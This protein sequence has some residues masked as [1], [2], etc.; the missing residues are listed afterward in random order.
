VGLLVLILVAGCSS[1][2]YWEGEPRARP[3]AVVGD[4]YVRQ[5]EIFSSAYPDSTRALTNSLTEQGWRAHV[6]GENGWPIAR[7]R[8][9]AEAAMAEGAVGLVIV[10]GV[11]DVAWAQHQRDEVGA[12]SAIDADVAALLDTAS[13]AR[14]VVWPTV[15]PGPR[16]AHRANRAVR[17]INDALRR[18]ASD[19]VVVPEWGRQLR[20][21]RDR[22]GSDGLHLSGAGEVA[23]RAVLIDALHACLDPDPPVPARSGATD[24]DRRPGPAEHLGRQRVTGR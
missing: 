12:L 13:P 10:A 6:H 19:R 16:A 11:N 5:L 14:C 4:S 8:E 7:V 20:A 2:R 15:A 22:I 21:H 3:V 24:P 1:P 9:L 18:R 17:A 23:L